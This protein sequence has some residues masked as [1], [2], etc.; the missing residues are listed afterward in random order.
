MKV[1]AQDGF[2]RGS[3]RQHILHGLVDSLKKE[4]WLYSIYKTSY[5]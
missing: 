4:D 2:H 5:Q 3:S 1:A